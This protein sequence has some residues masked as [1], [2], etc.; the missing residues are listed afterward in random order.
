MN[1]LIVGLGA[2]VGAI[3]RNELTLLQSKIKIDFPVITLLINI[4]GALLLGIFT[5]QIHNAALLLLGTGFCG[6]FTTF[7]T[8][9]MELSQLWFQRRF[10]RCFLYFSLTYIFGILG[11]VIGIHV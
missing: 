6:G 4:F 8:L 9:N 5:A 2:S 7:G 3:L 10:V 11:F 1:F